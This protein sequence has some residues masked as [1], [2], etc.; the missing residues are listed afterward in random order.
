MLVPKSFLNFSQ[1]VLEPLPSS[2]PKDCIA[3]GLM[4]VARSQY[5][6]CLNL[7]NEILYRFE[8]ATSIMHEIGSLPG[9]I[10]DNP[11][12]RMQFTQKT[13]LYFELTS[14][15]CYMFHMQSGV[16]H[17]IRP[18]L[19]IFRTES[20]RLIPDSPQG[21]RKT[22]ILEDLSQN[23][24]SAFQ[25]EHNHELLE[26]WSPSPNILCLACFRLV[27]WTS[28]VYTYNISN[29]TSL[30]ERVGTCASSSG[31]WFDRHFG[32]YV[33][34][35]HG[36]GTGCVTCVFSN[37][38]MKFE[39]WAPSS[40]AF[41][42]WDDFLLYRELQAEQFR[43]YDLLSGKLVRTFT[44]PPGIHITSSSLLYFN[45]TQ[46]IVVE[47]GAKLSELRVYKFI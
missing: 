2:F 5:I 45:N 42:I 10:A 43:L 1:L 7:E 46:L 28:C 20:I 34:F 38:T 47:Q 41:A 26:V 29:G 12:N 40:L 15:D 17:M 6:I 13:E 35:S 21:I 27:V 37:R 18:F 11:L 36:D 22:F 3:L 31:H 9:G 25:L 8:P 23:T 33:F 44:A 14:H 39:H 4:H 19:E 24:R 32:G 16:C 30:P